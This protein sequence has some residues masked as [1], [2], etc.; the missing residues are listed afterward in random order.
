[1]ST[2]KIKIVERKLGREG[3]AGMAYNKKD[4]KKKS[5]RKKFGTIEVDPRVAEVHGTNKD[6]M[7]TIVHEGIH[8]IDPIMHENDVA[9][10]ATRLTDI[11]WKAGYRKVLL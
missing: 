10:F 1:M 6:Y 8:M 4:E 7:D 2:K 3:A 5:Y 9:D 11:L